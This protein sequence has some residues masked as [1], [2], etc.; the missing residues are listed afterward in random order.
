MPVKL[1]LVELKY[2]VS[3]ELLR[4]PKIVLYPYVWYELMWM[5][6]LAFLYFSVTQILKLKSI[7][8]Y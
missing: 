5:N 1:L 3:G 6:L 4:A 2:V 7:T 8:L